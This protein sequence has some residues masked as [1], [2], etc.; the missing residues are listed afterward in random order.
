MNNK[1]INIK[2]IAQAKGLK[3]TRSIRIKLNKPESKY[4][5]REVKV[6]GGTSYEVLFSSLE[7]ELQQK[8]R[9]CEIKSTVLVSL[10][11][12]SPVITD[13]ARLT[14]NHRINIVKAALEHRKNMK[15]K[16]RQILNSWIYTILDCFY[17]KHTNF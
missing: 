3:S 9:E 12:Q 17:Q 7:P 2:E 1:Y 15:L 8:I 10:N 4:V 14:A 16:K 5:S 6:N 11:Y 13:K